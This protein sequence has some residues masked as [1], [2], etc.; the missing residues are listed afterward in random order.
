MNNLL[1]PFFH[2]DVFTL[3]GMVH[4]CTDHWRPWK[5]RAAM[6]KIAL[7]LIIITEARKM[8]PI[9]VLASSHKTGSSGSF[10]RDSI[11]QL[12]LPEEVLALSFLVGSEEFT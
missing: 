4:F 2:R 11:T 8:R 9:G 10:L 3:P 5:L 12:S 7:W 1:S 6:G